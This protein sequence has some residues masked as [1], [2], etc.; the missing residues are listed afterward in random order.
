MG[1]GSKKYGPRGMG[2]VCTKVGVFG[3]ELP[4]VCTANVRS[5]SSRRVESK[6][7]PDSLY[8]T[9]PM[10]PC[11]AASILDSPHYKERCYN[12][13]SAREICS[14]SLFSGAYKDNTLGTVGDVPFR[15]RLNDD[16][17]WGESIRDERSLDWKVH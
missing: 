4:P 9:R 3:R 2:R 7:V 12:A 10:V 16:A 8:H 5:D 1:E 13:R 6:S 17:V 14:C 11:L 15:R